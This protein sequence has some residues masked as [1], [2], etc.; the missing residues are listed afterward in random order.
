MKLRGNAD[1]IQGGLGASKTRI[2]FVVILHCTMDMV[3]SSPCIK[4]M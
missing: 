1:E 4:L 2:S 3:H